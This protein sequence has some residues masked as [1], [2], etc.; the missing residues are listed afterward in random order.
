MPDREKVIERIH[1]AID[2]GVCVELFMDIL[3]LL[4]EQEEQISIKTEN[5]NRL[6]AKI[7]VMPKIVQCKECKHRGEWER[8]EDI[9]G[10]YSY[11]DFPDGSLC[12]G[13]C[14]DPFYSWR[15]D[16]DWYCAAGERR[17]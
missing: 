12:P 9:H 14:E 10:S 16:D 13:Q 2:Y 3:A 8:A 17:S 5:F 6:V 4:K 11:I 7:G 1:D 15:P